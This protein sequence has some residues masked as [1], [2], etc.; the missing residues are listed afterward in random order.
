MVL[1]QR[2]AGQ[3]CKKWARGR[4]GT[5]FFLTSFSPLFCPYFLSK[6]PVIEP[7]PTAGFGSSKYT[8]SLNFLFQMRATDSNEAPKGAVG[9]SGPIAGRQP[10]V[11]YITTYKLYRW[12]QNY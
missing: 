1:A 3:T 12:L 11:I 9:E 8:M 4:A 6:C 5:I 7:D 2:S 10:L